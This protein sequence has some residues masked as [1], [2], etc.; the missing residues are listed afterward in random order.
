MKLELQM[1]RPDL[2]KSRVPELAAS[3]NRW[4]ENGNY[5]DD[6][7]EN[8]LSPITNSTVIE[9]MGGLGLVAEHL[10]VRGNNVKL[11]EELRLFLVYRRQMF[12]KSKVAEMNM[13]PNTIKS[14][15]QPYDCAIIH[16]DEFL[17]LA[18]NIAKTVYNVSS[19]EIHTNDKVAIASPKEPTK[20]PENKVPTETVTADA[21]DPDVSVSIEPINEQRKVIDSILSDDKPFSDLE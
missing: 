2:S 3:A 12:P 17:A 10:S 21:P 20:V 18:K 4:R 1:D 13:H 19:M 15:S 14:Q 7:I 5:V 9:I 11:I 8:F 16:S 6:G